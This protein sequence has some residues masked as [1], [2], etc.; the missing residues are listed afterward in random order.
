MFK[1]ETAQPLEQSTVNVI[2]GLTKQGAQ[3]FAQQPVEVGGL[4][5][6]RLDYRAAD[7]PPGSGL[8]AHSSY[9]VKRDA[10]LFSLA[11]ATRDQTAQQAV[12]DRIAASFR[13]LRRFLAERPPDT[14]RFRG[15]N[16][17]WGPPSP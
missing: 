4:P 17:V 16:S 15:I 11:L 13:L 7:G 2:D 10:T 14:I 5:G 12:L 1:A 6:I 8:V 3:D 9:R